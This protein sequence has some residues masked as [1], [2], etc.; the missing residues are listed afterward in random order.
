VTKSITN[1]VSTQTDLKVSQISIEI[2]DDMTR[3]AYDAKFRT[4][5]QGDKQEK[6]TKSMA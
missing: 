6:T 4:P 1:A 5:K 2:V 3:E